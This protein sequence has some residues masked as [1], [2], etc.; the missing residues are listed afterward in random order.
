[1]RMKR[2][3]RVARLSAQNAAI[4]HMDWPLSL[5]RDLVMRLQGRTGH[6][7]RLEWLYG[8]DTAPEVEGGA[9]RP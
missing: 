7:R 2:V 6:L 3:A 4:F 5:A 1:M 9:N 8:F